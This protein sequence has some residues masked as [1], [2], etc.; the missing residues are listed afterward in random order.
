[1]SEIDIEKL[2][3][4]AGLT[5]QRDVWADLPPDYTKAL[6]VFSALVLEEAAHRCE[7]NDGCG[8]VM[9]HVPLADMA[10][11]LRTIAEGLKG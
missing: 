3:R 11:E 6:S 7:A 9:Y 1:M 2:A 8:Y 4:E 5:E 10:E